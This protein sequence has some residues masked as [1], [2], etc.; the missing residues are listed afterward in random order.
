MAARVEGDRAVDGD[1][2]TF[3]LM[4]KVVKLALKTE[5]VA[6]VLKTEAFVQNLD[7]LIGISHMQIQGMC[8]DTSA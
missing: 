7:A 2:V 1:T 8:S 6:F 3:A 4:P 5:A